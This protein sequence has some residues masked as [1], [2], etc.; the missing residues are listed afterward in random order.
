MESISKEVMLDL[1][2]VIYEE[3]MPFNKYWGL[4]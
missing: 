3:N 2:K 1:M 4:K